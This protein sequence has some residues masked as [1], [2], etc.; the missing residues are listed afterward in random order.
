MRNRIR[1]QLLPEL[2]SDYNPGIVRTL[3][4][5]SRVMRDEENWAAQRAQEICQQQLN[6]LPDGSLEMAMGAFSSLHPALQRRIVR[7]AVKA[8]KGD[9]RR[10]SFSHVEAVLSLP[11]SGSLDLPG[12]VCVFRSDDMIGFV[13]RGR[14]GRRRRQEHQEQY[15]YRLFEEVFEARTFRIEALGAQLHFT[16]AGV[17]D[18]AGVND[19]GQRQALFDMNQLQ[20]PLVLRNVEPGDRFQPLGLAGN[21]KVK[22]FFI[23]HKIPREKRFHYPVLVSNEKIVW[24]VGLRIADSVKVTPA[25]KTVLRAEVMLED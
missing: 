9:L 4:R 13:N 2:T 12:G 25:T 20:L 23:D 15:A 6:H 8:L 11:P 3:E 24:L 7:M 1:H 18:M 16:L 19:A 14:V 21:Q 5:L 22:K 17:D 10:L